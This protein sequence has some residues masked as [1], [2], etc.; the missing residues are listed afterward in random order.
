MTRPRNAVKTLTSF[1]TNILLP[2][3]HFCLRLELPVSNQQFINI[4]RPLQDGDTIHGAHVQIPTNARA[5]ELLTDQDTIHALLDI[6]KSATSSNNM[7]LLLEEHTFDAHAKP[8]CRYLL[9]IGHK[10]QGQTQDSQVIR[11]AHVPLS[12][13]LSAY[14]HFYLNYCRMPKHSESNPCAFTRSKGGKLDTKQL[15]DWFLIHNSASTVDTTQITNWFQCMYFARQ[16]HR[17]LHTNNLS[18]F[19]SFFE[20]RA[21][22]LNFGIGKA[23]AVV[24]QIMSNIKGQQIIDTLLHKNIND[25][26]E[27]DT[28][29]TVQTYTHPIQ[30]LMCD[31]M[32]FHL[33]HTPI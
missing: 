1:A 2:Y 10:R 18:Q 16:F 5:V 21:K 22:L 11:V 7:R 8:V 29:S 32:R 13:E 12:P 26:T 6:A 23:D 9:C 33:N 17:A 3:I 27:W 15:R 28:M 30:E 25:Y 14:I 20:T 24:T 4:L 31:E 19:A